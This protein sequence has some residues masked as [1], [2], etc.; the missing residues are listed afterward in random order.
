MRT[1]PLITKLEQF[2]KLS[3][4]D[5]QAL[6][7]A[8]ER[9]VDY[10]PKDDIITQGDNP[11]G[12][13]LLIDGWAGRDKMLREG[14]RQIMA[15]LIPGD[16]CDINIMLLDQMD[17]SIGAL[18]P[19][20]V[21]YFP[22]QRLADLME[23]SKQLSRALWWSSLVDEAILREWL[24]NMGRR[25]SEKRIAHL[26]CE[27]LLRSRAVGLTDDDTFELPLTQEQLGDT[28]GMSTVHVNRSIQTLR[29]QNLITSHG[30][31]IVIDDLERLMDY[32]EFDPV[33][34]H[35][36]N[37]KGAAKTRH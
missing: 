22:R 13:Y 25:S 5:K 20:K 21:L 10:G 34:L 1:R 14:E 6:E 15:F 29:G 32:A 18:S 3:D 37:R 19:C 9:V 4:E 28:L 30:R 7:D 11:E 12:V 8:A 16:L 35:Q 2:T 23:N 33:Y 17:H 36:M 26:I 31:R 24:V 27:M